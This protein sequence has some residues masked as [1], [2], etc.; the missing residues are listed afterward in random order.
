VP[1]PPVCGAPVTTGVGDTVTVALGVGVWVTVAVLVTVTVGITVVVGITV[2]VGR[3]VTFGVRVT[4]GVAGTEALPV[5]VGW[6]EPPAVAINVVAAASGGGDD[7]QPDTA[8]VTRTA[9]APMP[10]AVGSARGV[11]TLFRYPPGEP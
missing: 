5:G 7:V 8:A 10:T 2:A 9:M 6:T 4:V 3:T 11:R 1:P